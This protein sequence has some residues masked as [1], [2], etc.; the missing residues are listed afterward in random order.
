MNVAALVRQIYIVIAGMQARLTTFRCVF[1]IGKTHSERMR[2]LLIGSSLAILLVAGSS[3]S[4][5]ET[6]V[7]AQDLQQY[8]RKCSDKNPP[9]CADKPP[10][11]AYSFDPRC[12]KDA[13]KAKIKGNVVLSVG[14]GTDGLAHDISVE[15]SLG[16]GL[17]E[18]A[19]QTIRQWR[20]KPGKGSG[21]PVPVQISVVV[22]FR[23]PE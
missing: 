15:G 11:V 8:L 3:V 12:S 14:V 4:G 9:P 13:S 16:Y 2:W 5:Q 1:A 23:C 19:I 7:P 22:R 18:E 10:T 20:F 17:D 6:A 21:K